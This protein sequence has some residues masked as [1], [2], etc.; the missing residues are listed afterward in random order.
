MINA[1]KAVSVFACLAIFSA[2]PSSVA[3]AEDV[4]SVKTEYGGELSFLLLKPDNPKAAVVLFP[5]GRGYLGLSDSGVVRRKKKN[6]F[7]V[8]KRGAFVDKDFMVAL[9]DA[10]SGVKDL[11]RTYRMSEKHS[12]DIRAVVRE[13]KKKAAVPVW[14]IGHSRGTY[15]AANG[16]I[17]LKKLVGGLILTSTVTKPREKYT[18]YKTHPNG[19]LSM[20]LGS[21]RVPVLIVA[22]KTDSC[23]ST[24]ASKAEKLAKAFTGTP[25][26][27]VKIFDG[28]EEPNQD[29]CKWKGQHHFYGFQEKAVSSIADFITA[30]AK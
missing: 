18:S 1:R 22:N 13:L 10:P 5:G 9:I 12:Q 19:V 3:L 11:R 6:S 21:V 27:T 14:L 24:P 30:N 25:K 15:S 8:G 4:V 20:E 28:E 7:L 16:A 17:R 26:V 2:S 23:W 29:Y